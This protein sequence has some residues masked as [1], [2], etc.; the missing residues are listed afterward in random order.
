MHTA[1]VC[2]NSPVDEH[3]CDCPAKVNLSLAILGYDAETHMHAVD[4]VMAK[5]SLVDT[6]SLQKREGHGVVVDISS[7]LAA[8]ARPSV[9]PGENS[10]TRAYYELDTLAGGELPGMLVRV[11]KR[12]PTGSGL[13]GGSSDAAGFLRM[14]REMAAQS[15]GSESSLSRVSQLSECAWLELAARVGADVPAF[16]LQGPVRARGFGEQVES[17]AL[18]GLGEYCCV[19][20]VPKVS[21]STA[22]MYAKVKSFSSHDHAQEFLNKWDAGSPEAAFRVARNDFTSITRDISSEVGDLLDTLTSFGYPLVSVTGSGSCVF[23][24]A[25]AEEADK[26]HMPVYRFTN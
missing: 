16:I 5:I 24:V 6:V 25:K 14:V 9:D 3:A 19:L 23:A 4:T 12:I 15:A 11:T 21:F 8:D 10:I 2:H 20:G 17:I 13:G 1:A 26:V 18:S 7:E 22:S